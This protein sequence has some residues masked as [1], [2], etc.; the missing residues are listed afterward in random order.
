MDKI[1]EILDEKSPWIS[2][3]QQLIEVA[4]QAQRAQERSE[5]PEVIELPAI[6][7]TWEV[8]YRPTMTPY[9]RV[10]EDAGLGM[11]IVYGAVK[12]KKRCMMAL[13]NWLK[14]KAQIVLPLMLEEVASTTR[15]IY[16]NVTVR[17]QT[18]RWGSC[19]S[20]KIISLNQKL[21]FLPHKLAHYVLVHELSHTKHLNHSPAYWREVEKHL[22]NYKKLDTALQHAWQEFIPSWAY[23]RANDE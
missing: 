17:N 20:D 4:K 8:E 21:L 18:A 22:P 7:E 1:E 11:L 13:H 19:S 6:G 2:R 10:K 15:H 12:D 5:L 16:R 14:H 23:S 9:V 3:H